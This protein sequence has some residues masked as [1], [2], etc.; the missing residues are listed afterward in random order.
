[1]INYRDRFFE[2]GQLCEVKKIK[3]ANINELYL[4]AF[5]FDSYLEIL[6]FFLQ[7]MINIVKLSLNIVYEKY[8]FDT[9]KCIY[10]YMLCIYMYIICL[11]IL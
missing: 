6:F 2:G 11:F 9:K 10:I 5:C 4:R 7:L 8:L 1:M 3:I